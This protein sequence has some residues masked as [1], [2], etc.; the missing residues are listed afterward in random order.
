[1]IV[2]DTNVVSEMMKAS[3]SL[4]VIRW[5]NRQDAAKLFITTVTIAEVTYGL[6]SMPDGRR[7]AKLERGFERLISGGFRGRVL[8]L[9]EASAREYGVLMGRRK[10]LGHPMSV[11]DGLIAAVT[12][13]HGMALATRNTR[14]FDDCSLDLI[15][16]FGQ[17]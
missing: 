3:P 17:G 15:D 9:D 1:M 12:R 10:R 13:T 11:L 4:S 8:A 5:L 2:I 16:P 7:R 6:E 14:D